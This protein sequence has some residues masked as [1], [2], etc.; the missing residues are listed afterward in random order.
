VKGRSAEVL[1]LGYRDSLASALQ[2]V[3]SEAAVRTGDRSGCALLRSGLAK[4]PG[5]SGL[6]RARL[7]A[8][9]RTCR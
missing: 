9:A 3:E 5:F 7:S 4:A 8:T 6:D 1:A 2:A